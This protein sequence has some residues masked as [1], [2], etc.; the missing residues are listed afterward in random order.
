MIL[1]QLIKNKASE[2]LIGIGIFGMA[3]A[4]YFSA[5]A[6]EQCKKSLEERKKALNVEKLPVKEVIKVC[7]K[8]MILPTLSFTTSALCILGSHNMMLKKNAALALAAKASE[9]ALV[10]FKEVTK[11]TVGEEA[12]K[13]IEKK[14]EVPKPTVP[15]ENNFYMNKQLWWDGTFNGYFRHTDAELKD[16]FNKWGVQLAHGNEV[17]LIDLYYDI[18]DGDCSLQINGTY[19]PAEYQFGEFSYTVSDG[20]KIAPNGERAFIIFYDKPTH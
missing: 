9:T 5:K 7:W 15:S 13:E 10:D 2:L 11:K 16:I 4:C 12:F 20:Y 8:P 18:H 19:D 14:V 3:G 1:Q 17:E 6:Y